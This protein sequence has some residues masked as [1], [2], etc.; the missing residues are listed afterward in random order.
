[1]LIYKDKL[2]SAVSIII[3]FL[4]SFIYL[5]LG[6]QYFNLLRYYYDEG[7]IA[8]GATRILSGEIPYRDFWTLYF[9]G[10]FYLLAAI[11]K[12]FGI[13]IKVMVFFAISTLALLIC[14][15]YIFVSRLALRKIA[16][17][18]SF[19]SLAC[20]K[21]FVAYNRPS[22]FAIL[23]SILSCFPVLNFIRSNRS[24]WLIIAGVLVGITTLFRQD[25]GFYIFVAIFLIIFLKQLSSFAGLN[26]GS[27]LKS[28]FIKESNFFI[29][30]FLVILP[31]LIYFIHNSALRDLISDAILF[32]L[33]VYPKVRWLPFP[34]FTIN[35]LIFYLPLVI[36]ALTSVRLLVYNWRANLKDENFWC[37]LLFLFLGIGLFNYV[38]VRTL[39]D[40]LFPV[41]IISVILFVLLYDDFLKKFITKVSS[42]WKHS[43]WITTFLICLGSLYYPLNFMQPKLNSLISSSQKDNQVR[44]DIARAQ[45]FYDNSDFAQSQLSAIKYIQSKTESEER[46]FV[47]KTRHDRIENNDII[48]YFL[49][50]R[51]S[52]T[53]YHEFHPGLTTTLEIQ[54]EII[55]EIK[56]CDVKYIVLWEGYK[57]KAGEPNESSKSSHVFLLDD[58][59]KKNYKIEKDFGQYV[60]LR[61]I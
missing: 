54:K 43:I 58:F 45:G 60:I 19:L 30:I 61:G 55:D 40:H 35:N 31:T 6:Y 46:I 23:F 37:M 27:Q 22:Q 34:K 29:G 13:S 14:C 44:L 38:R 53:R 57:G 59:I 56:K 11:F 5:S 26:Y 24:K 10:K 47:G 49:S 16:F 32:P 8:Y 42:L 4:F 28:I 52:A 21:L 1:M 12:I 50:E 20:L 7:L 17:L 2:F 39:L 51:H 18:S 41:L 33:I 36:F 15:I 9:P 25:F 48:F 3:L